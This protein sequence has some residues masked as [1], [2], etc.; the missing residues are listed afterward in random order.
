MKTLHTPTL[1]LLLLAG[2]GGD[3]LSQPDGRAPYQ[4]PEPE[5]LP[6]LPNLDGRIESHELAPTL[7]EQ[8]AFIVSPPPT[9]ATAGFPVNVAGRVGE[10]GRRVWDWSETAPSDLSAALVARPLTDQWYVADFPGGE[11]SMPADLD[12]RLEAVYSHGQDALL[13]HGIASALPDPP[14]GRTLLAYEQPVRFFPFPLTLGTSWTDTGVVR[15]GI[16]QGLSPWSQDDVYEVAVVAAGELRLPDFTFEQALRVD[17][18]VTIRPKAGSRN[19][20]MQRQ[21]SF[22]FEC[23]G[24]V[25]RAS[26]VLID[27]PADDPG[28]DF[29]TAREVRRLGW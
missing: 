19:G 23:F 10:D 27:E 20:Y 15:S 8:A 18:K 13:L 25:A 4:G 9:A 21:V 6:C 28:S 16:L 11:F 26:S 22:V 1:L 17:S 24:E 7:N 3:N 5:P 14:E 29:T 2:C 12:G